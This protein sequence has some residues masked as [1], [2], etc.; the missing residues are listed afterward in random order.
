MQKSNLKYKLT[1]CRRTKKNVP[2]ECHLKG[3]WYNY[4]EARTYKHWDSKYYGK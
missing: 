1:N 3:N 4:V 2:Q